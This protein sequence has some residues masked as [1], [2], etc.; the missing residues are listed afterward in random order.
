[1]REEKLDVSDHRIAASHS[2][3]TTRAAKW[4]TKLVGMGRCVSELAKELNC[5]WGVINRAVTIY[6]RALLE[7]DKKRIGK[8]RALGFDETL[9]VRTGKYRTQ[10]WCT[11]ICDVAETDS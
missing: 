4:A 5:D 3:L 9:F 2:V 6:S 7:A 10:N 1:M 8:T 11:T